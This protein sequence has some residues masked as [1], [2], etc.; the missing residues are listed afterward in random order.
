MSV[1]ILVGDV[2]ER[3]AER[4]LKAGCPKGGMVLDPFGGAGTV[5]LVA[6][7]MGLDCTLIEINPDYAQLAEKRI[8]QAQGMFRSVKTH[9]PQIEQQLL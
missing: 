3:L 4:C 5:G 8:A 7:G 1:T 6:D 9:N 2:R